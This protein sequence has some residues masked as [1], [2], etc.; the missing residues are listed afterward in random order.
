MLA[1]ITVAALVPVGVG[2]GVA[3]LVGKAPARPTGIPSPPLATAS[4]GHG[5]V[6]VRPAPYTWAAGPHQALTRGGAVAPAHWPSLRVAPGATLTVTL[7]ANEA[8]RSVALGLHGTASGKAFAL[9]N[10]LKVHF[11][12]EPGIDRVEVMA[13][14]AQG[15]ATYVLSVDVTS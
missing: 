10:P 5:T 3:Q 8:P 15:S 6:T 14:W 2:V 12:K 13:H 4:S 7:P 9:V 1:L 11:G